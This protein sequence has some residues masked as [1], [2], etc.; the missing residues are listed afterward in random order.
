MS[1]RQILYDFTYIYEIKKQNEQRKLKWE[2][3]SGCQMEGWVGKK[4]EKH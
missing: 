3:V 1:E 2:Q 4:G